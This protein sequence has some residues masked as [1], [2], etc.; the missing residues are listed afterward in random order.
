MPRRTPP[1]SSRTGAQRTAAQRTAAQRTAAQRTAAQRTAAQRPSASAS[2]SA[3]ASTSTS[4][5]KGGASRPITQHDLAREL[6]VSQ[7]T[8]SAA[9]RG[10]ERIG[11]DLRARV[12]AAAERLGYRPHHVAAAMASG[13]TSSLALVMGT[14]GT[15]S[16]LPGG[17][18]DGIL[19]RVHA[20]DRH[21]LVA[22]LSDEDLT[23]GGTVP[24]LLR[25]LSAD[26]MLVNYSWRMPAAL[27]ELIRHHRIPAIHLNA[28]RDSDSVRPDDYAAGEQAARHL[29]AAGHRRI[30]WVDLFYSAT[31]VQAAH[32]SQADRERGFLAAAAQTGIRASVW[33]P[34]VDSPMQDFLRHAQALL[35][36]DPR[37][38]GVAVNSADCAH[39][40]VAE[41]RA[42]GRR[43]GKDLAM[44]LVDALPGWAV[45]GGVPTFIVPNYAVGM[46]GV[47]LLLEK[48][49]HPRRALPSRVLPFAFDPGHDQ[50]P[51]F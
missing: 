30:A 26:G 32:Y 16:A 18:L 4:A 22:R 10:S 28:L 50:T 21:L 39:A 27:A 8:I 47:E 19:G 12:A 36:A 6:D 44:V 15:R 11:A 40:I 46:E 43:I 42:L 25:E 37:V 41:A 29:I 9:L 14:D 34:P 7:N 20:Q 23:S 45:G 13:R 17:M 5:K 2:A 24:R 38:T 3:S 33:R 51:R 49:D 1:T 35:E 48:I 31:G